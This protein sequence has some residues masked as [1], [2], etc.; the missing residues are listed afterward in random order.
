LSKQIAS[1]VGAHSFA[2]FSELTP[3][4]TMTVM[5][6]S[7]KIE[8]GN[9]ALDK[10]ETFDDILP[11]VGE[12]SRYQ[13]FLFIL[14]LPFTFVYAFMYFVQFFIALVPAEHWCSIPELDS[15]NLTDHE[16]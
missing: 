13:W 12:A 9:V 5:V 7:M 6:E 4:T 10:I 3:T 1:A 2:F 11:H 15:W 14:L 8:E 16:K